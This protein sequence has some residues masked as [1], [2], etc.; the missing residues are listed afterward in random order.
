[1]RKILTIILICLAGMVKADSWNQM[2]N[3]GG[4]GRFGAAGFTI[5]TKAF[6]GT[7]YYGVSIL[8]QDFWEWDQSTNTWTQKA[9]FPYDRDNEVG[10]SIGGKGYFCTGESG[11]GFYSDLWEYDTTANNWTQ[12]ADFPG[13]GRRTAV[14][15]SIGN[16][17]Y[18]GTGFDGNIICNDFYEWDQ[19]SNTWTQ[20]TN[21]GGIGRNYAVG[22]SIGAKGYIGTGYDGDTTL[23]NDLW[24]YDTTSN[25]WTQKANMPGLI[26]YQ[27]NGFSFGTNGFI[28]VGQNLYGGNFD[29][30]YQWNQS[31]NS[32]T[33]VSNFPPVTG[34]SNGV[35]FSIGN[36]GYLGTGY[37]YSTNYQD[38]WEYTPDTS[39]GIQTLSPS[40]LQTSLYPNPFTDKT[41]L[42]ITGNPQNTRLNIFNIQGQKVK[43]LF[44]GNAKEFV[45]NRDHLSEGIY[46]Y[47]LIDSNS[48][49]LATGKMV[50]E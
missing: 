39:T 43:S 29:D 32:W 9:N 28:G 16:K 21:F 50:V 46:F 18:V 33:Q 34:R 42:T 25:A 36:K 41:T 27:S 10:F 47:E 30:F 4:T 12:R 35:S 23:F 22:F 11:A 49:T 24:E 20:K 2:T 15:F 1:M 14:G 7:G 19:T 3:F 38:F 26:R 8:T 5:G 13:T 48:Q 31:T 40:S 17:G 6:I 37:D 44:I 45:I